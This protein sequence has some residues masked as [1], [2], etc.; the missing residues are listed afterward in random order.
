MKKNI[1][2]LLLLLILLGAFT[3]RLYRIDNPLADWH[4]WRQ[5]DTAAVSR[6]FVTRGFDL[7]HP[8]YDDIANIQTGQNNPN[9]YRFVEFPIYNAVHAGLAIIFPFFSLE[10]WGR[11]V[12]ILTSLLAIAFLYLLITKYYGKT[13][14]LFTAFFYG[15]IPYN[16]YYGRVILPDPT[17]VMAVLGGIYFF[18]RAVED[19]KN[20]N[21]KMFVLSFLFTAAALLVKPPAVFFLL[22]LVAIAWYAYGMRF[23]TKWYL[24]VF[25]IGV[26]L[27]LVGWRLWMLQYPEGI[28]ANTWL[29]NGNGIRF[30]PAFFRWI[31]YER[32][33]RLIAGYFGLLFLFSGIFALVKEKKKGIVLSFVLSSLFYVTVFATGN[34]QH[35]YY[36]ILVMPTVAIVFGLG[37]SVL[38]T[39]EKRLFGIPLGKLLVILGIMSMLYTGWGAVKDY[40]NI[41]NRAIITAGEAVDNL[42]PKDALIV[43]PYDGDTTLLYHTK[44]KGWPAF[45]ADLPDLIALGADYLLLLNPKEEHQEIGKQYKIVA[46]TNEYLLFDLHQKP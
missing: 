11:L 29:L 26:V 14:G 19:K 44:R 30:R 5:V 8:R 25:A 16:I 9:G 37:A 22:P 32:L 40:F 34:V 42:T 43:A 38:Y 21:R 31:L 10:V 1:T 12:T 24:W 2:L 33:T 18:D 7:L 20:L 45:Q 6:N 15:F 41:N 23:L 36:Q 17:M 39:N 3:V 4:S 46:E 35:D 27:P 28:P 13:T